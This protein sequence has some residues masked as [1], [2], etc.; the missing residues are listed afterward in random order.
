VTWWIVAGV[1]V[2]I[3]VVAFALSIL[4]LAKW[5]DRD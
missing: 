1:I 2:W 3:V 4:T 5:S